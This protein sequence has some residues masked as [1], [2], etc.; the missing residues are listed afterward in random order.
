MCHFGNRNNSEQSV[1]EK[2]NEKGVVVSMPA[3]K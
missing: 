2:D 3:E 1:G